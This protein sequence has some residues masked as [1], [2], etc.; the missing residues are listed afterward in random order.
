[1]TKTL[2][3]L[4][5]APAHIATFDRLCSELAPGVPTRHVVDE[6][7]LRDAREAGTITPE[8]AQRVSLA[9]S[10]AAEAGAGMI[11]CTCSTIGG[12]A[13]NVGRVISTLA[14]RGPVGGARLPSCAATARLSPGTPLR[15][16]HIGS[17]ARNAKTPTAICFPRRYAS[18]RGDEGP[19][20]SLSGSGFLVPFVRAAPRRG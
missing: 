2:T 16:L 13:E 9:L 8:L 4:H 7:L 10:D 18:G 20:S 12:C 14:L 17:R 6:S 1:M 5:T 11:L 3:F 15:F 19:K